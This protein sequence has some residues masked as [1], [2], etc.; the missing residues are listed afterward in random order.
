MKKT[1]VWLD[2]IRD[3]KSSDY[4]LRYAPQFYYDGGDVIWLKNYH[5]FTEWI[6]ENGV[7]DM[8]CFDHDLGEE[9]SGY[10]AA[11]FLIQW[12]FEGDLKLPDWNVQSANPVGVHN[13]NQLMNNA[14]K[15][16][17]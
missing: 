2:D 4:L 14:K 5:D 12:C 7:P 6:H 13:I 11:K 3:P 17:Q 15:H 8:V 10:D 16:L 1:L 9:K